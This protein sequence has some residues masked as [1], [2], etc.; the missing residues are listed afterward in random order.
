V[1]IGCELQELWCAVP[2]LNQLNRFAL[3][4]IRRR[5]RGHPGQNPRV[6]LVGLGGERQK[7]IMSGIYAA[8]R[9]E[10]QIR[11]AVGDPDLQVTLRSV[12]TWK[13]GAYVADRYRCGRVFLVG[14]AAHVMP[15]YGGFGGNTGIADAHNL[16]WK[17][18]AVCSG[19]APATLLDTYEQERQPIAEFTV[20][21]VLTRGFGLQSAPPNSPHSQL[22][23][24]QISLGY[25]YPSSGMADKDWPVQDPSQDTGTPGMR[26]PHLRLRGPVP[27]TLD[28]LDPRGFTFLTAEG[29]RFTSALH[30]T[31]V[32]GVRTC[33]INAQDVADP[34]TWHRVFGGPS[35]GLLIR[36]DGIVGWL[37]DRIPSDPTA[38]VACARARCIQAI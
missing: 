23:P 26:A 38:A 22:T 18:A 4:G 37:A 9:V 32:S 20:R 8:R 13:I 12:L 24:T 30:S 16:A 25:C 34:A 21:H 15:P 2:G 28:L 35:S 10:R 11:S 17:L 3:V 1:K 19:E 7:R 33:A 27:S 31:P 6:L 14:D 36:P 29:S 5:C